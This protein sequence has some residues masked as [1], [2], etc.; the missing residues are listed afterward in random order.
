[1][2]VQAGQAVTAGGLAGTAHKRD[3]IVL[4]YYQVTFVTSFAHDRQVMHGR[5]RGNYD[6]ELAMALGARCPDAS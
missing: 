2:R 3:E 5:W 1:V 4:L 6:I